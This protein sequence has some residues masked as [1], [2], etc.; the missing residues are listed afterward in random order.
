M[1]MEFQGRQVEAQE[2]EFL[3]RKED[4]SEYQLTTGPVI[5]VKTVVT[6]VAEL[7]GEKDSEGNPVYVVRSTNVIRVRK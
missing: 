3:T 1:K 4:W 7:V 2:V 6:D 5:R